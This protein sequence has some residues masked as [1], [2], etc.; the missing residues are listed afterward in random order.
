MSDFQYPYRYTDAD[1]HRA[2]SNLSDDL[3][4]R[5]VP[6]EILQEL[7]DGNFKVLQITRILADIDGY[8]IHV[9]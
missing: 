8:I 3:H 1:L 5:L 6:K 9:R 4:K 2:M 7:P